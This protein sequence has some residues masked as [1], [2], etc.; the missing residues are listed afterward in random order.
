MLSLPLVLPEPGPVHGRVR[1]RAFRAGDVPM[2]RDLSTDPYVPTIGSLPGDTD[3]EG[4]LAWITRQHERAVTGAGYSFCVADLATDEALGVAG[5]TL[6]ALTYGRAAAGYSVAPGAR[7]RRTAG[8]ALVA[9][10]GFAWTVPGLHRVEL[11]VEPWNVASLRTAQAA[12]Y[13]LEG[14]LHSHQEIAGRRVDM[15]LWAA[16][17]GTWDGPGPVTGPGTPHPGTR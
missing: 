9:L 4:A 1:L 12:G 2:V 13:V 10:T 11:Y 5:L 15:Q 14:T 8:Q 3:E 16:V 17:R 6:A 7:G